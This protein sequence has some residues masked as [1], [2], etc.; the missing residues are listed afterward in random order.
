MAN[1]AGCQ[2]IL[3][4]TTANPLIVTISG[5]VAAGATSIPVAQFTATST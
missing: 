3:N 4:P 1:P 2:V 5:A